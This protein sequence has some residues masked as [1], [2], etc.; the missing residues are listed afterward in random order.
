MTPAKEPSRMRR[1]YSK[2]GL[3]GAAMAMSKRGISPL[4]GPKRVPRVGEGTA[5]RETFEAFEDSPVN[6]VRL[7]MRTA[8]QD[9]GR[10][11]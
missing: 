2:H 10:S 9:A 3:H 6:G 4:E 11:G 7:V 1:A 8:L 5:I